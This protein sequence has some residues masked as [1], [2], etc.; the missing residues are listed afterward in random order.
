LWGTLPDLPLPFLVYGS[1]KTFLTMGRLL[2]V[3]ALAY[4]V[5]HSPITSYLAARLGTSNPVV[6]LGKHALVTFVF[7]TLVSMAGLILKV[8]L[9][10]GPI[11][12]TLFVASGLL[13]LVATAAALELMQRP[14]PKPSTA[15]VTQTARAAA[16]EPLV[17]A[18]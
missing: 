5:G 7:G 17:A 18:E 11:F 6:L 8:V 16:A 15:P 3:L 12:D 2:H 9:E 13:L 10:G 4:V 14:R 1:D